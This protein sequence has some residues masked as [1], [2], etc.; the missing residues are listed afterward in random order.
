MNS[1]I[2]IPARFKSTR[3]PGKPL[4]NIDGKTLIQ[5]VWEQ[6]IH[7]NG[8]DVY[9]AT[10]S[11]KIVRHCIEH[12]MDYIMTSEQCLT[13]TDRVIEAYGVLEK[14]YKVVVNVQGDEPL[15]KPSDISKVIKSCLGGKQICCGYCGIHN[16]KEFRSLNTIKVV[17]RNNGILLYASRAPI[18]TDKKYAFRVANKQ[19][20]IYAYS[21]FVIS[22]FGDKKTPLELI[23][24]IELLRF[25][26][27][28]YV[29][30]MIKVSSSSVAVDVPEDVEKIKNILSEI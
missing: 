1:V 19:V 25:L 8:V 10:D 28:G 20:C 3:F 27:D 30:H 26:E 6:C 13:G 21:S 24:D 15:V 7:V 17:M 4:A 18:P 5:R 14:E 12:N 11:D 22:K 23:E 2:I 16:E 9:V 29:I